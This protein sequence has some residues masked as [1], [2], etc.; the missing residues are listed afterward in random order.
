MA[1]ENYDQQLKQAVNEGDTL[2]SL[3]F[4]ADIIM[5]EDYKSKQLYI[6]GVLIIV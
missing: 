1:Y 3:H 5:S 6:A 4:D 2:I